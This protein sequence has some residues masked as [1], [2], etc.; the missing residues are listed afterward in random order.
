VILSTGDALQLP[1]DVLRSSDVRPPSIGRK[2]EPKSTFQDGE[3][4]LIVRAC[5]SRTA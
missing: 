3:R 5:A 1:T 4:E 2:T